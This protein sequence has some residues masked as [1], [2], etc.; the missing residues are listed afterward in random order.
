MNRALDLKWCFET[1]SFNL[2]NRC[3]QKKPVLDMEC[4]QYL[5]FF[6]GGGG[7]ATFFMVVFCTLCF[8]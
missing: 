8:K 2:K 1:V 3:A 7:G 6:F 4:D 5:F